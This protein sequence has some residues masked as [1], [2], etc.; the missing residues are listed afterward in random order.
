[1]CGVRCLFLRFGRK[2]Q[3]VSFPKY[4]DMCVCLSFK[5][6]CSDESSL[7]TNSKSDSNTSFCVYLQGIRTSRLSSIN[8]VVRFRPTSSNKLSPRERNTLHG[9]YVTG[10]YYIRCRVL[11]TNS[12]RSPK[13][14]KR[15][16][17][18][19]FAKL[20]ISRTVVKKNSTGRSASINRVRIN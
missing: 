17:E 3:V 5:G 14:T 16:S 6:E 10:A 4:K 13:A 2:V 15:N 1:M 9:A 8:K 19:D 11:E 20:C 12:N 7:R 18:R